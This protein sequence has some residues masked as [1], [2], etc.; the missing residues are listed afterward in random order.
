MPLRIAAKVDA[1]D[2]EYF[3]AQIEPLLTRPGIT[4]VGEIGGSRKHE[5]LRNAGA[6]LFPIDWR[7]PFGLVM[8]EAMA[9]GTPVVA[10]RGGS[11]EEV[12]TEGVSGFVVDTIDDAVAAARRAFSLDRHAC[13]AAFEARFTA[14]RMARDYI[15]LYA[16]LIGRRGERGERRAAT[17]GS[18]VD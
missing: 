10:W 9:C 13:R 15:A 8:I 14:E 18:H 16:D 7:E 2:R 5:F 12:I 11:V 3:A 17:Q 4:F 6:L 1:V